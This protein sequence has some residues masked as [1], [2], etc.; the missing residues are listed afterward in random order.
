[1]LLNLFFLLHIASHDSALYS[2]L[3]PMQSPF[4]R[5]SQLS[6]AIVWLLGMLQ[7]FSY[8]QA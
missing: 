7:N 6:G 1:M 2:I 5:F 3:G 4:S 8:A